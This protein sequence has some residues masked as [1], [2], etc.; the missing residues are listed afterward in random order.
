MPAA[1]QT[2]QYPRGHY[3]P[4]YNPVTLSPQ[5]RSFDAPPTN[6]QEVHPAQYAATIA[7]YP[8]H[9][10]GHQYSSS[11]PQY[12]F[13]HNP[14]PASLANGH[15]YHHQQPSSGGLP[16]CSAPTLDSSDHL[17]A[18]P[19]LESTHQPSPPVLSHTFQ[20][21]FTLAGVGPSAGYHPHFPPHDCPH[22]D[23]QNYQSPFAFPAD[24]LPP[25]SIPVSP[26]YSN[27]A[28]ISPSVDH[29]EY[30]SGPI[31]EYSLFLSSAHDDPTRQPL[32]TSLRNSPSPSTPHAIPG[33]HHRTHHP[34]GPADDTMTPSMLTAH[35]YNIRAPPTSIA[36]IPTSASTRARHFHHAPSTHL[37]YSPYNPPRPS[38]SS[39]PSLDPPRPH[40]CGICQA[41]FQRNH[42][43]KRHKDVHSD[44]KPYV[45]QCGRAFTRKDALKRHIFLKSC[46]KDKGHESA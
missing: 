43:L 39:S 13:Q 2:S 16:W 36:G 14:P 38:S 6:T 37:L 25:T 1:Q 9:I 29:A 22:M 12:P 17:S 46:G 31:A 44:T 28:S 18:T 41:A 26:T 33:A 23:L 5:R 21:H 34:G 42:D 3:F 4:E 30:S 19:T 40:V 10:V 15:R 20:P 32:L 8:N 24:Q 45:C 27:S 35:Q 7:R 11:F